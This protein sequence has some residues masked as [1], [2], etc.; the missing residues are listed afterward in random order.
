MNM[1][2]LSAGFYQLNQKLE[3]EMVY[4]HQ[5]GES[6]DINAVILGQIVTRVRALEQVSAA[7]AAKNDLTDGH[8]TENATKVDG[9]VEGAEQVDLYLG[10]NRREVK[11]A[12]QQIAELD[13]ATDRRLRDELNVMSEKIKKGFDGFAASLSVLEAAIASGGDV[14]PG[15]AQANIELVGNVRDLAAKIDKVIPAVETMHQRL[16]NAEDGWAKTKG[17]VDELQMYVRRQAEA[18][19]ASGPSAGAPAAAASAPAAAASADP[20]FGQTFGGAARTTG[21]APTTYNIGTPPTTTWPPQQQQP[22]TTWPPQQQQQHQRPDDQT[23]NPGRWRLYD[24]K[25]LMGEKHMYD[26]KSPQTWMQG[27]R[28]YVAGR[29]FEMDGI[30]DWVAAQVEEIGDPSLKQGQ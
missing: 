29:T 21:P 9:L 17:A 14:P 13:K 6:V 27:L 16:S 5:L 15:L 20:W 25:T 7:T 19:A 30:L 22:T 24:E 18:T 10:E 8:L 3:Q 28:D 23:T 4:T 26:A 11:E 12:I 1:E 2:D